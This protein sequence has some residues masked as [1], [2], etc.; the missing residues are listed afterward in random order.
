MKAIIDLALVIFMLAKL[1]VGNEKSL[2]SF[3]YF[4]EDGMNCWLS[5]KRMIDNISQV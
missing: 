5:Q 4:S 3:D 1:N 2:P